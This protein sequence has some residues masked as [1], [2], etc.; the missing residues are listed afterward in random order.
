MTNRVA[1][2][3]RGN[4]TVALLSR[5]LARHQLY[6]QPGGMTMA[7]Q[8]HCH[9]VIAPPGSSSAQRPAGRHDDGTATSLSHCHRA[10]WLVVGSMVSRAA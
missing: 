9:T 8:H 7:R 10:T 4:I 6:D 1:Q 2:R 5:R 3:W